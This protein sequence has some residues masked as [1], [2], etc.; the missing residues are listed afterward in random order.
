MSDVRSFGVADDPPVF[1]QRRP[2]LRA[3]LFTLGGLMTVLALF[4]ATTGVAGTLA[5]TT[6]RFTRT[7]DG[8]ITA[9]EIR[10]VGSVRI[11][12]GPPEQ[13]RTDAVLRFGLDRPSFNQRLDE[14]GVLQVRASCGGVN[15]WCSV[16]L[17]LAVP[18][19][20]PLRVRASSARLADLSGPVTVDGSAGDVHLDRLSGPLRLNLGAGEIE[21][22]DLTSSDVRAGA[23]AG[24]VRLA[25]AEPPDDVEAR[26]GAGEVEILVPRDGT[27]YRVEASA[28]AGDT[29]VS[30][31]TD[32][33]SERS[34]RAD[35]GAGSA[36]V[37]YRLP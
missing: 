16:D 25:F 21:G 32:P 5:R 7:V 28:G 15:F 12:P 23:G 30:V 17:D 14:G 29:Q 36:R 3:M 37:G 13:A 26:T 35:A 34:I 11:R 27:T 19:D 31:R 9:V 18:A 24:S 10:T 2:W 22:Q 33:D 8:D 20:V 6:E 1:P 4:W